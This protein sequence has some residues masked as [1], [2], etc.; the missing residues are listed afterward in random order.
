MSAEK[1]ILNL[2][3]G[4]NYIPGA[5]NVDLRSD[6]RADVIHDL[7]QIPWP[8]ADN[9][10]ELVLAFHLIEHMDD[11]VAVMREIHRVARRGA[12]VRIRVPHFSSPDAFTDPT[13]LHQFGYFS[14]H[15]FSGEHANAFDNCPKFQRLQTKIAFAPSRVRPLDKLL[16]RWAN[17][18]PARYE[19]RLAWMFPAHELYNEAPRREEGLIGGKVLLETSII[20]TAPLYLC[21][22]ETGMVGAGLSGILEK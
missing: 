8:F 3:C 7:N 20:P 9:C 6:V 19:R 1:V 11:V 14:F 5:V 13:H 12:I 22:H 15:F 16:A 17:H 10:F 21:E 4:R 2:G 18:A